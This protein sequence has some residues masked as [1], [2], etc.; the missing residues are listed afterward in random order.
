FSFVLPS[1]N[2]IWISREVARVV[3][4]SEKGTGKKVLASVGYHEPSLVFWLGTRTRIDSLQEAIKDL[5]KNRLT[6][7]L[8]FEEF[9][10]PLLMATKRRGIRLKMIRHFRGFN[11]SKGKWRNLY[12]FKV[13]SP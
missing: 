8:V 7:L 3:N 1:G 11:Y 10:E 13:V 2:A 4:H 5:E 12:L 9:K 6:H